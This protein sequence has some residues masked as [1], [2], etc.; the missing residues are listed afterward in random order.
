MSWLEVIHL[1][2]TDLQSEQCKRTVKHLVAEARR[3]GVCRTVKMYRRALVETDLSIH[4]I[5]D[6]QQVEANGSSLGLRIASALKKFG[7]IHH[8]VWTGIECK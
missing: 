1:R 4:L 3:E 8:T 2:M 5:H 6:T 7:M